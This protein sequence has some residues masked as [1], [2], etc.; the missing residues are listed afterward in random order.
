MLKDLREVYL[1][2][3]TFEV[4]FT[5]L[6]KVSIVNWAFHHFKCLHCKARKT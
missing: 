3:A 2:E 5:K 1:G 6:Q 4:E